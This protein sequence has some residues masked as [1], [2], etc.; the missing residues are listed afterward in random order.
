MNSLN[1]DLSHKE[2][3]QL[4]WEYRDFYCGANAHGRY[5]INQLQDCLIKRKP[6]KIH[7]IQSTL[8]DPDGL[9]CRR[10]QGAR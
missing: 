3:I 5:K 6:N 8:S 4:P 2:T 1:R 9:S 7:E 10:G